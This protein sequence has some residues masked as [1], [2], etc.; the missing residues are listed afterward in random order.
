MGLVIAYIILVLT[1]VG[2]G[3]FVYFDHKSVK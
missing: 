2:L 1:G 3:V